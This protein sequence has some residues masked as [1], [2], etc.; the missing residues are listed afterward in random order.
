VVD[1]AA[2]RH[3]LPWNSWCGELWTTTLFIDYV[4]VE[5]SEIEE[6]GEYDLEGLFS[7]LQYAIETVGAKRVALDTI[8][9]LF[10]GLPN[11]T[12]LRSELRRL[13][14]WLKDR[15]M[16]VL[17]TGEKGEGTLTRQ[18]LEEY[19]SDCVIFLDHRV[20]EQNSTRRLRVVKYRGTT[21]GTNEYPFLIDEGGISILPVTSLGLRH[22]AHS[23]RVSSGVP[24]L[25]EMLGGKGYY[26]G[27]TILISGTAGTGKT[28][29]AAHLA[30]AACGRGEKCLFFAFEESTDQLVRNMR[31]IGIHL[32]PYIKKGQIQILPSRPTLH[33]LEMHLVSMHKA[34]KAFHP[35]LVIVDP[36]TNLMAVGT[37][38]ETQ[39]MLTRL[40]DFLKARGTT[41]CL[42]SLTSG[43]K[44]SEQS[45]VGISSLIDT[46]IMLEVVANGAERNRTL[47][48]VKSRGM[49]H[50]NQACD[51]RLSSRGI[52]L[53]ASG[54][55][56]RKWGTIAS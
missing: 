28:S 50:S 9:S 19:V 51:C 35:S 53:A 42:T 47:T 6:T 18:G 23:A 16:T 20:I 12:I 24:R 49:P 36:I 38:L 29:A 30:R 55:A 5:R 45:E 31:S 39:A 1:R 4:R 17:L 37:R 7:R 13:F 11:P 10:S 15:K 8:E 44:V 52:E 54:A 46:W 2:A 26:K 48:I 21:H 41:A 33:G 3:S 56:S 43:E 40:I 25:D 32:A 14:R 34:I 22:K 27:S